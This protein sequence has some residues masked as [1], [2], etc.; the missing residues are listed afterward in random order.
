MLSMGA[1]VDRVSTVIFGDD[2]GRLCDAEEAPEWRWS[3]MAECCCCEFAG[4]ILRVIY[5]RDTAKEKGTRNAGEKKR[6]G[7]D[8]EDGAVLS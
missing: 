8:T 7:P 2:S 6:V 1:V 5:A 3:S 4:G